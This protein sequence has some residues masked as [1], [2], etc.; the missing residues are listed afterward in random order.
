MSVESAE[1]A[2]RDALDELARSGDALRARPRASIAEALAEA[3]ERIADP[4]RALGRAARERLPASSGLTLPMV[5]W[6]LSTT[7][8]DARGALRELGA[9]MEP[10]PG[11]REAPPRLG[12]ILLAGNVFSACVQPLCV[13]LLARVP[14]LVKASSADDAMPRLFAEALAEVDPE[15]AGACLVVSLPRGTP[16]LE[17]TILHRAGVVSVYGNDETLASLRARLPASTAFV[18]HGHGLGLGFVARGADLGAAARA[19]A[20]DV[21]AYD[22]RGCLSPHAIGVDGD[23]AGFA[24]ALAEALAAQAKALPRGALP[25]A[26]GAAQVQWRGVA[27]A[28]GTLHEGDGWAVSDEGRAAPR[29]SPGWRNVMVFEAS[30]RTFAERCGALGA[31]LKAV[32]V[33]GDLDALARALPPGV[34]PRVCAAGAM[35]TPTLLA[36]ADGLPPWEGWRRFTTIG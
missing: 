21:A 31:H 12:A 3:W 25:T 16:T 30:A 7:L 18:G 20:L 1:G 14:I 24:R 8:G 36:Y 28:R 10:P 15:L 17:A 19:L 23:A 6:A 11:A 4:E 35:Q 22:Q 29:L 26:V 27:A 13:G 33:A 5:A 2:L 9:R 34:A 32:G